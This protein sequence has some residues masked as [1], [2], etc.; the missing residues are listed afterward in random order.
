MNASTRRERVAGP[1]GVLETAIDLP[2]QPPQGLA[3]LAHPHPLFGGTLDNK[4]VQTLARACVQHGL[5]AVRFNTRGTGQSAGGWDDGRGE[6]DDA[7]AV[8]AHYRQALGLDQAPL[9]LAGF[10]FGAYV[11]SQVFA[12]LSSSPR[13]AFRLCL[14]GPAVVNFAVAPVPSGTLVVQ[15]EAD[16]VVPMSAVLRWAEAH[17]PGQV[18][19]VTVV[20]AAG[21]F[22]HGQLPV[23]KELLLAWLRGSEPTLR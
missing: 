13:P 3:V 21:H 11:A 16:D 15:G 2:P 9:T 19:P 6:V 22:F 23:L 12:R 1:A 10:S 4:V 5:A 20:P 8:V 14:V 18:T 17:T 7:M